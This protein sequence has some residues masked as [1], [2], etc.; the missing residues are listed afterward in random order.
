MKRKEIRSLFLNLSVK[1]KGKW[2]KIAFE[3]YFP[4]IGLAIL[5]RFG[6]NS[7]FCENKQPGE[8]FS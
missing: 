7:Q 2:E 8:N 1:Q 5:Y 6:V 4:F 3:F